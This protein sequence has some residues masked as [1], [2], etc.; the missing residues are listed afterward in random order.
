[1]EEVRLFE[2]LI[3]IHQA[4]LR[5]ISKKIKAVFKSQFIF[6]LPIVQLRY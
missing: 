1:M 6:T 5:H 3:R 4:T 2:T